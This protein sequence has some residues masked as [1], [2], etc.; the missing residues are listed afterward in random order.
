L[1][2][3]Y[4]VVS[5]KKKKGTKLLFFYAIHFWEKSKNTFFFLKMKGGKKLTY[6]KVK[7]IAKIVS[8]KYYIGARYR[9]KRIKGIYT[10]EWR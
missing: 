7:I 4:V 6:Q 10:I 1:L 5:T 3:V 2:K 8:K 9:I